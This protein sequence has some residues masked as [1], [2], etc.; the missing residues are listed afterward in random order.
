MKAD[1]SSLLLMF[2]LIILGFL[3]IKLRILKVNQIDVLPAIL[4]NVAYPALILSSVTT[5]DVT[6]LAKEG[7]VV[8]VMTL[9]ITLLLFFCGILLLRK[10]KDDKRKPLILFSMAVGNIA[11][12]VLP[13]IQAI[14]GDIGVY[15]TI[16]HS[17]VQDILIWTLYY[18]YFIGGGSF[19]NVTLKKLISPSFIALVTAIILA[20]FKITPSGPVEDLI[21]SVAGLTVPLALIY[22]GGVMAN[23]NKLKD[24]ALDK[25]IIIL[26][27]SKVFLIPI[28]TFGIM[29]L[30]PVTTDI[31]LLMAV[32]FSAPV[33]II[34]IIWAKQF[35][36]DHSFSIKSLLFST[37]LFL[38][39][40]SF[41]FV[42]I[43]KGWISWI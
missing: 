11:Y 25:D 34:S 36:F 26:S 3:L 33:P 1:Y 12:V 39:G 37:T 41:L 32:L 28:L 42:F 2:F 6:G 22:I 20:I 19:R 29:Q 18:A 40:V 27:I 43:N 15:L 35:K 38:A 8:V 4:L 14:F 7:I 24:W 21:N 13:V 31:K 10:Y 5:V 9:V 30:I 17:S 23:N 16:L